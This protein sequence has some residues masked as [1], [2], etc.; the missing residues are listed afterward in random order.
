MVNIL[1][2]RI[3]WQILETESIFLCQAL[4]NVPQ[5]KLGERW[6]LNPNK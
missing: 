2:P 1:K 4:E 5:T 3:F 6:E